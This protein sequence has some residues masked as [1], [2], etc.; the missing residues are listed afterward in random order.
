MDLYIHA[1][2]QNRYEFPDTDLIPVLV[3]HFFTQVNLYYPILHR[4]TFEKGI[5]EN[6]HLCDNGFGGVLLLV[7]ALGSKFADD[8]RVSMPGASIASAGWKWYNQTQL[9]RKSPMAPRRLYDAQ[10]YCVSCEPHAQCFYNGR[11]PASGWISIRKFITGSDPKYDRSR[12]QHSNG[13]QCTPR[14]GLQRSWSRTDG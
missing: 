3:D 11:N 12:N 1:T 6:L 7:C 8:P 5:S 4:P 10:Q 14:K 9:V 2:A 13:C